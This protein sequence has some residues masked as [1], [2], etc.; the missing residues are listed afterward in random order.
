VSGEPNS[1]L[2][3]PRITAALLAL[4]NGCT[5][6]AAAGAA[7]VTRSTFWLWMANDPTFS[8]A[9]EKAE[10][11]AEA[12]MTAAVASKVPTNWQAAAWWLERRKYQDYA[13]RDQVS[14]SMDITAIIRQ[15]ADEMGIDPDAAVAEA[16]RILAASK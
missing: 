15:A 3:E 6:G 1:K 13:R 4:E 9:V 12:K 8:D 11:L 2:T 10:L 14:V 7:G 5:R 16:E